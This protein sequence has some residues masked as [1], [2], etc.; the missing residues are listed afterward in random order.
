MSAIGVSTTNKVRIVSWLSII[1]FPK[2]FH[3]EIKAI[4]GEIA[5]KDPSFVWEIEDKDNSSILTVKSDNKD[6]AWKRVCWL[7][8]KIN[9]LEGC[10][11]SVKWV[12][13]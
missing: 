10:K 9:V 2:E 13:E 4:M 5:V 3:V 11:F 8:N 12:D 1:E 6:K 7:T